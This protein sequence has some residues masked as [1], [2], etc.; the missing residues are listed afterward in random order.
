MAADDLDR[1]DTGLQRV[2]LERPPAGRNTGQAGDS[3]GAGAAHRVKDELADARA[4]NHDVHVD[5]NVADRACMIAGT[6]ILD[7]IGLRFY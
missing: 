6:Q 2:A 1:A 3:V 5:A 4:F 7:Q